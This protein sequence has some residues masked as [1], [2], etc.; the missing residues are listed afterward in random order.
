M[1]FAGLGKRLAA[2]ALLLLVG[3]F[4]VYA[5]GGLFVASGHI[6]LGPL[7]IGL[8]WFVVLV[9][10]AA[11]V[12]VVRA[13]ADSLGPLN[14]RLAGLAVVLLLVTFFTSVL[15][16]LLPGDPV[17]TLVPFR[18]EAT[19]ESQ[20]AVVEA[21]EEIRK[22]LNLDK[23][24]PE[25][26]VLWLD[27][28]RQGDFGDYYTG[29]NAKRPVAEP[30]REAL[31]PSLQLMLYSQVL[32]LLVA[33]PLGVFAAYRSGTVFDRL[34]NVS[35]FGLLALPNFV[36]AL[37]LAFY[38][39]TQLGWLPPEG[40]VNIGDN[41][42][43]HIRHM[44]LPAIAL[45]AGQIAVYMRLLRSDMVATLQEDF[46]QMARSKGVSN[47]RVLWRHAFRPSTITL[48][49]VAGL[50]VGNLI[51]GALIVEVIFGIPGL[52]SS[53]FDA[54]NARAYVALQSFVV[55]I[56]VLYVLVNVFVDLLYTL[57]DPRI[58]HARAS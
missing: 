42:G 16:N 37:V 30:L 47:Q 5:L 1:D 14:T 22:E 11:L 43:E 3:A 52:G 21:K 7:T 9:G 55:V 35:A 19:E 54:I 17:T 29:I 58:R 8:G 39:G 10:I 45:S 41:L 28:L 26:Y 4:V 49:T 40:Y 15:I 36:V 20:A 33:I 2:L 13:K 25:R 32:A 24:V 53:I 27:D 34:A 12:G 18:S 23:S 50:N 44:V 46:V 56:A 57:L 51:G 6:T 38:V 31:G 48:L